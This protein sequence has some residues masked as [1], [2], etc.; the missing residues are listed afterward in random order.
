[1]SKEDIK[2]NVGQEELSIKVP[3]IME[4]EIRYID[5]NMET[6][7]DTITKQI[8]SDKDLAIA[9]YIIQKLQE[10]NKKKDKIIDLMADKIASDNRAINEEYAVDEK[11]MDTKYIKQYFEKKAIQEEN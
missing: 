1:M 8:I 2:L 9:Q 3:L 11:M 6:I 7:V 4:D 5:N 10:E